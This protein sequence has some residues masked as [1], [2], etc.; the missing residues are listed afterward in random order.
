MIWSWRKSLGGPNADARSVAVGGDV[1]NSE[2]T[3]SHGATAEQ[4][5]NGLRA[6]LRAA[7]REVGIKEGAIVQLAQRISEEIESFDQAVDQLEAAV[8]LFVED[9]NR[10]AQP[11]NFGDWVDD[12][13]ARVQA[14]SREGLHE[15]GAAAAIDAFEQWEREEAERREAEHARGVRLLDAA[16]TQN[17]L[18]VDA[19]G[20]AAC[21]RRRLFLETQDPGERFAALRKVQDEWYERGRDRGLNLDLE[22]SIHL[23]RASRALAADAEDRG[24]ALNDLGISLSTLGARESGTERLEEAV[25]AYRAALEELT[26]DR[27][28][29][30]WATTQNNLGNALSTLGERESGTERLE[31]AVR[32]YRAALEE[33]IR[34]RVPYLWGQTQENL[35]FARRMLF[36]RTGERRELEAA[37]EHVARA[38]EVYREAGANYDI[39]RAERLAAR[40]DA[41]RAGT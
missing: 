6:D 17:L 26:R 19:A 22:V 31:E 29:L 9:M 30:D 36:E 20:A 10:G 38:L 15:E 41:L 7:Y 33:R 25:R 28:P 21:I 14:F 39:G 18:D 12:V 35:A 24:A 11:S 5:V 8:G 32:A 23:A 13:L 37:A 40:I 1:T 27:V 4:M 34:D 3:I 2:V 16:L